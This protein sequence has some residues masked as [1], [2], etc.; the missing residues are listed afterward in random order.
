VTNLENYEVAL[1]ISLAV[2]VSHEVSNLRAMTPPSLTSAWKKHARGYEHFKALDA[3]VSAFLNGEEN[4]VT[5]RPDDDPK[6]GDDLLRVAHLP[7]VPKPYDWALLLGDA[8]HNFRGAL[9]HAACALADLGKGCSRSTQFP[10]GIV[11]SSSGLDALDPA[12]RTFLEARQ[13]QDVRRLGEHPYTWLKEFSDQDKH[14]ALVPLFYVGE[15]FGTVFPTV[16]GGVV[17]KWQVNDVAALDIDTEV[18]RWHVTP[19]IP[20]THPKVAM[21]VYFFPLVGCLDRRGVIDCLDIISRTV[22]GLLTQIEP[23]FV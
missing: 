19:D 6:T 15:G 9:D 20:G 1:R 4:R 5:L 3:E 7:V 16:D 13:P 21:S 18:V 10:L 8:V 2:L 11:G 22:V 23:A 14:R 17:D 12:H